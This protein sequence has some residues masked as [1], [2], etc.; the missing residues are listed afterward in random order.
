[1][2][3]ATL[4][5]VAFAASV[6]LAA[7]VGH[8]RPDAAVLTSSA[9]KPTK[10]PKA[11]PSQVKKTTTK[12]APTKS[13]ST[14]SASTNVPAM[15]APAPP[16]PPPVTPAT[17][18]A[19][20]S[21]RLYRRALKK[22]APKSLV[23]SSRG[24]VF[25]QNMIYFHSVTVFDADG[26]R[27]ADVSDQV[28]RAL[29]G[30]PE[31][32]PLPSVST[33]KSPT[34]TTPMKVPPPAT[35]KGSPVEAAVT[36]DGKTLYVS[37]YA[38]F[39]RG[40]SGDSVNDECTMKRATSFI[41][42]IDVDA[43]ARGDDGAV[44]GG[45]AVGAVPKFLALTPDESTLI[46]SNWCGHSVSIVDIGKDVAK[47]RE[48]RE[49]E[50]N[51]FPR[52]IAISDDGQE[53]FIA[54]MGKHTIDVVNLEQGEVVRRLKPG[55]GPRHVLYEHATGALLVTLSNESALVRIDPETGAV[56]AR[57]RTGRDPRSMALSDDG[58]AAY[59]VNYRED[60]LAIV[61]L[62]A[63]AVVQKVATGPLP[64]G[65]AYEPTKERIWVSCY[66]GSV[67]VYDTLGA[68]AHESV[69]WV[70]PEEFKRFQTP[71]RPR[72]SRASSP[73]SSSPSSSSPTPTSSSAA[74]PP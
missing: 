8:A 36:A 32:T 34:P 33:K 45:F 72:L 59:I 23:A 11:T 42:E 58:T 24:H 68:P 21:L 7:Y 1:M 19:E 46:V 30:L 15:K 37:N 67:R 28:P 56:L 38:L 31:L 43:A 27:L 52:G 6:G 64:I 48:T 66:G 29:L 71:A 25:A 44:R 2:R 22:L 5:F 9:A 74:E 62:R 51:S 73:S 49:V 20:R 40:Y 16:P 70:D 57:V 26:E 60:S 54:S 10:A 69:R 39:G 13:A 61:D 35:V 55:R 17:P 65:V 41:Y 3:I 4:G 12:S 47:R 63:M 14:K 50:T 53:A 18:L